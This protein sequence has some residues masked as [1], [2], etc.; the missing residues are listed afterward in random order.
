MNGPLLMTFEQFAEI[1]QIVE[2]AREYLESH[3]KKEVDHQTV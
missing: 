3:V 2:E 1:H